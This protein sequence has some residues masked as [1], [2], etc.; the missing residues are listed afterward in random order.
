MKRIL[1]HYAGGAHVTQ[2]GDFFLPVMLVAA[3]HRAHDVT[4]ALW[5]PFDLANAARRCGVDI[6]IRRLKTIALPFPRNPI[7]A[8]LDRH[9]GIAW[10]RQIRRLA[11]E[12][13]IC[14]S[15]N[16]LVDFG[17]PGYHFVQD[18]N[19]CQ[20]EFRARCPGPLRPVRLV[21]R[22]ILLLLSEGVKAAAGFRSPRRLIVGGRDRFFTMSSWLKTTVRGLYGPFDCAVFPPP[23]LFEPSD[24]P[25]A[26]NRPLRVVYIGRIDPEKRLEDIISIVRQAREFSGRDLRLSIAGESG[27]GDVA[28]YERIRR[29]AAACDW[30]EL[31]GPMFGEDKARFLASGTF[32]VHARR[33]EAFG[34]AVTEY[35][36]AG[37]VPLVPDEGGSREI[38]A[39]PDLEYATNEDAARILARLA[40]DAA[41]LARCRAHCRERATHFSRA[42]YLARQSEL[43]EEIL[44]VPLHSDGNRTNQQT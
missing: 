36:K 30:A 6:D 11:L 16:E 33:D 34:I 24:A 18:A 3:L 38:V 20:N 12:A 23:T 15:T 35:L 13:D 31:R 7:I 8:Y 9:W 39:S 2:G 1:I 26:P 4:L 41:F 37:V 21:M 19:W 40:T 29:L 27:L 32:A 42:A 14:I 25:D 10:N 22:R 43:L 44:A 17:K 28:Y 5:H